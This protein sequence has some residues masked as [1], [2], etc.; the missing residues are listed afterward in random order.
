MKNRKINFLKLG[1]L[2]FGV[3]LLFF[4][5]ESEINLIENNT[6]IPT[7]SESKNFLLNSNNSFN[8]REES[9]TFIDRIDWNN[10]KEEFYKENTELLYSPIQ[11]K[12]T[13]AKSFVASIKVDGIIDNRIITLLYDNDNSPKIF[14]GTIFIHT[15]EGKLAEVYKYKNGEKDVKYIVRETDSSSQARS[16]NDSECFDY[17]VGGLIWAVERQCIDFAFE[18]STCVT[19]NASVST[20]DGSG[21]INSWHEPIDYLNDDFNSGDDNINNND[22]TDGGSNWYTPNCGEG[23]ILDDRIDTSK[24]TG[25]A[26]CLNEKLNKNGNTFIKDILKKFQGDSEFD[27]NIKSVDKVFRNNTTIELNGKTIE[28]VNNVIEILIS[29][30]KLSSMPALGAARTLIHEYI[31]ADMFRKLNTRNPTSG[32]LD[33]KSTY[34]EFENGNFQATPQHESMAKLYVNLI[35]DVLKKFHKNVLVGDY[36]Y[37]TNNGNNPLPDSFYEALAWQGLKEHNVKVYTDLSTPKKNE[38]TNS[39]NAHYHSTTKNCPN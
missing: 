18:L 16:S 8:A 12:T 1:I 39:L 30:N 9:S 38:L 11:L 21:G 17:D 25:K 3:S 14:S 35:R 6:S 37:L 4:N 34:D 7:V 36:N 24:L 10:S 20:S 19:I 22:L 31:H 32:D 29:T 2:L 33:F 23:Y 28:A 15:K 26:E 13:K 27:I 5:C